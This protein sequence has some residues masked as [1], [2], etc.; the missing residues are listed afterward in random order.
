MVA[1]TGCLLG[2][3]CGVGELGDLPSRPTAAAPDGAAVSPA[4]PQ[5]ASD[6]GGQGAPDGDFPPSSGAPGDGAPVLTPAELAQ[7]GALYGSLCASCHGEDGSG[8]PFEVPLT[9]DVGLDRLVAVIDSD[10]PK[11][12]AAACAGQC[13]E[14]VAGYI[15]TH[16]VAG[17]EPENRP[18]DPAGGCLEEAPGQRIVRLLTRREYQNTVRD[19]LGVTPPDTAS[20]PVEPRVL[21]FDNNAAASVVTSRHADAYVDL[22]E[23]L[24]ASAVA[25]QRGSLLPCNSGQD[26]CA[27]QFVRSLGQR[28]FRRPLDGEEVSRFTALFATDLTGGDF[29]EGMRLAITAMLASPNF[30]YRSELGEAQADGSYRLTPHE[31]ASALSY[32]FTGSMP[33]ATL[34]AAAESGQLGT[35][36]ELQGQAERLLQTPA[37]REQLAELATQ[38]LRTEGVLGANKDRTLYP[39]FSDGVRESMMQEQARFVQHLFL[40]TQGT[41]GELF[42][43]DYVFVDN[44]LADF[45][46]LQAA[47]NF[48]QVTAP[49][50][51]ARGGLLSLGSV[52]ASHAHSNESSP[53]KRGLFVRD[54]LLCQPLPDPPEDVDATP[55]GLDPT[56]TTRERFALHTSAEQCASCHQYIDGVGFGLEGFDGVGARRTIENGLTVDESGELLGL[57]GLAQDTVH[58]FQGPRELGAVLAASEA[59]QDCLAVQYFRFGRGHAEGTTDHCS[60][61]RLQQ[62]FRDGGLSLSGLLVAATQLESFVVR[63]DQENP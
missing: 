63:A 33:D 10:M 38:W 39:D 31:T 20:I 3:A 41:F 49:A 4:S 50:D 19:L 11:G 56:L 16:F 26:G 30:L 35:P 53:I 8:G 62:A 44:A 24:A 1:I 36:A 17:A 12:N 25:T 2:V 22:A 48:A 21:G 46:G 51:S 6:P 18:S 32:L 23:Q 7:G 9:E 15:Q 47:G 59:A 45:Y 43:A 55:P 57:E 60:V 5:S 61:Q 52:L 27:E 40:D 54:R 37:A 42:T 28:A 34:F 58:E 14:L 13:A 29:D